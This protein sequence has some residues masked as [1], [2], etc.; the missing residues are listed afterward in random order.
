MRACQG[1]GLESDVKEGHVDNRGDQRGFEEDREIHLP[2][3]H[4]LLANTKRPGP[5]RNAAAHLHDDDGR[6]VA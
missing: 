5:G 2:V 6:Q 4:A 3:L 1:T